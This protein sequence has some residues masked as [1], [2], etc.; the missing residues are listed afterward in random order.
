[1]MLRLLLVAG[2][3]AL[4]LPAFA[5][6]ADAWRALSRLG[7]GPSTGLLAQ[8]EAASDPR[9]WA[10][11]QVDAAHAASQQAPRIAPDMALFNQPL[12]RLFAGWNEERRLRLQLRAEGASASSATP[13]ASG[14]F[15]DQGPENFS[16]T[17]ARQSAA[18][19]LQACSQPEDENPLLARMTEFWFN[20][21]NVFVGKGSV[22][23]FVGHYAVNVARAH[24]LGRFEDL[25]LASARHPAMLYYLDQVQSVAPGTRTAQG[26]TR[27]LNEN[28]ARELMELHTLGVQGGYSQNDVKELAR[29]LTGWGAGPNESTGYR[30]YPRLH[31][32]G[33]K[34]VLGKT[35]ARSALEAG[36]REGEEAIRMLARHPATA[37]RI[38]E[39]LARHF[40]ADQPDP[41]LVAQLAQVFLTTQ[42]DLRSVMRAL[43]SSRDFWRSD[44]TLFKTPLDYACSVLTS[45][46]GAQDLRKLTLAL[47]FLDNAG[48]AMHGWQTPDGYAVDAATWLVPEALTRRADFA[49]AMARQAPEPEFLWSRL[50]PATQETLRQERP[51]MRVGLMLASPE[52]MYK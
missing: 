15:A 5:A 2:C 30:F 43:V 13:P 47:G 31:D 50:G 51:A 29:V 32:I 39:R 49:L 28:Y 34:T 27:G 7:Y 33:S 12:P 21:L 16:R 25:L 26:G 37:Q 4:G 35:F 10:L 44:L 11:Q 52:F 42:G 22:R 20:H 19:R 8:V 41:A 9:Q 6:D 40:V 24:A 45:T 38:S 1:M 36:E 48:Q 3:I 17:V 18:W 46:Q 14:F 23:P